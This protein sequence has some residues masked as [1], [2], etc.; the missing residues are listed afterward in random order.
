M[1]DFTDGIARIRDSIHNAQSAEH[2][3][4]I[5]V[6]ELGHGLDVVLMADILYRNRQVNVVFV[7]S[8]HA[9]HLAHRLQEQDFTKVTIARGELF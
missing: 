9:R 2:V 6:H 4:Q 7:G 8:A 3:R 5:E 1:K